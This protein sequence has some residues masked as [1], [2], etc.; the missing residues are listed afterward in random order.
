MR[1]IVAHRRTRE[2]A[3]TETPR[4]GRDNA[5]YPAILRISEPCGTFPGLSHPIAF[6]SW[7]RARKGTPTA[8]DCTFRRR[9]VRQNRAFGSASPLRTVDLQMPKKRDLGFH[10]ETIRRKTLLLPKTR[11]CRT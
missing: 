5:P 3:T 8:S 9:Y 2:P 6:P 11:F 10:L 7:T 4:F 1:R